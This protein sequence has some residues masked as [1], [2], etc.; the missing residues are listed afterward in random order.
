MTKL[1][2]RNRASAFLNRKLGSIHKYLSG[3]CFYRRN[4]AALVLDGL[5][6]FKRNTP[7]IN[8]DQSSCVI[9]IYIHAAAHVWCN[10][11]LKLTD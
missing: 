1:E 10:G 6:Q 5:K 7:G 4:M 8:Q 9:G 11:L 3:A 2:H